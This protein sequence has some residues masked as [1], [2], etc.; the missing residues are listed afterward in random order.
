MM[1]EA[2]IERAAIA[3][4]GAATILNT[5]EARE[6]NPWSAGLAEGYACALEVVLRG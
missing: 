5:D 1:S 6:E 3:W 4:R 2:E